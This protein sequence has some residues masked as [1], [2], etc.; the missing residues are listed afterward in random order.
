MSATIASR[1]RGHGTLRC[2]EPQDFCDTCNAYR[3]SAEHHYDLHG[4]KGSFVGCGWDGPSAWV[5]SFGMTCWQVE[6]CPE[7]Q[8]R[9][10][11][12]D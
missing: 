3:S 8:G 12:E 5:T 10:E 9:V 7:C 2:V 6:E 11:A 4:C 1:N